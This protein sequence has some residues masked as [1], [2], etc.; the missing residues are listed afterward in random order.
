M[1]WTIKQT[2]ELTGIPADTL[3]YYDREGIV[4][5]K[6]SEGGYRI[7]NDSDISNLK[8]IVV[9]KYA[10]FSL[11]EIKTMEVLYNSKPGSSCNEICK[12]ILTTKVR[13][14]RQAINNYQNIVALIEELLPMVDC[15]HAYQENAERIDQF[16]GRIFH[17]IRYSGGPSQPISYRNEEQ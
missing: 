10:Q 11:A 2:A 4:S 6:R 15:V 14:L 13:E 3:R 8:N 16:I 5:P 1:A 17:D 9:M 12:D 7:Y